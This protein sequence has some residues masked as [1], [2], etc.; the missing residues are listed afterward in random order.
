MVQ[1]RM[2]CVTGNY[3]V[4]VVMVAL[5][6]RGLEAAWLRPSA[7][8]SQLLAAPDGPVALLLNRPTTGWCG[9][10]KS[11]HWYTIRRVQGGRWLLLDS[12][13]ASP[14]P[15]DPGQVVDH[16]LQLKDDGGHVLLVQAQASGDGDGE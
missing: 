12:A 6:R 13:A 14:E 10:W 1:V 9:L 4:D 11:N 16:A 5:M 7:D 3:G 2:P 8:L 15:M